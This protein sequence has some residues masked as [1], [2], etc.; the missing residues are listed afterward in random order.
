MVSYV[1]SSMIGVSW[2]W[3]NPALI[4]SMRFMAVDIA[5]VPGAAQGLEGG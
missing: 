2:W 1:G 5:V 3:I 4:L